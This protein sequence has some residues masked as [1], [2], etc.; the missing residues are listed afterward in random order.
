MD[1]EAIGYR[2]ITAYIFLELI[3]SILLKEEKSMKIK[4]HLHFAFAFYVLMFVKIDEWLKFAETHAGV[5]YCGPPTAAKELRKL[6]LNFT[7]HTSTTF[8]FHKENF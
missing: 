2:T 5:F 8:D 6:A 1:G 7:H 3:V 4:K